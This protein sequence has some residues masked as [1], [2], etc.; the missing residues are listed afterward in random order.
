M[1]YEQESSSLLILRNDGNGNFSEYKNICTTQNVTSLTVGDIN[2]DGIG[3]IAIVHREQNQIEVLISSNK[4]SSYTP[5]QYSVNYYPEKVLIADIDNDNNQDLLCYGKLSSGISVLRGKGDGVF[6]EMKIIF[7]EIPVAEIFIQQFNDDHFADIVLKN[8][9]TNDITFYFGM[10]NLSFSHQ[11]TAGAGSDSVSI[12]FGDFNND[13]ITDFVISS[14]QKKNLQVYEG[15]GIGGF[16]MV[17]TMECSNNNLKLF[18]GAV[19]NSEG[20]DII[21]FNQRSGSFSLFVNRGDGLLY[22]E[23]YFGGTNVATKFLIGD[24]DANTFSDIIAIENNSTHATVYWNGSRAIPFEK[25]NKYKGELVSFCVGSTPSGLTVADFNND[26]IE[27]IAVANSNS[28]TLSMLFGRP[29]STFAGQ[30]SFECIESPVFV[31]FYSKTDSSL[32]FLL[33]HQK[34]PTIS[35]LHLTKQKLDTHQVYTELQTFAVRTAENPQLIIPEAATQNSGI[36]YYV[37]SKALQNSFHYY[38][39]VQSTRFIERSFTP[40]FPSKIFAANIYDFNADGRTDVAYVYYDNSLER[41]Q[42]GITFSDSLDE[43]KN[44]SLSYPLNDSLVQ[45]SYLYFEDF[46]GDGIGDCVLYLF[47]SKTLLIAVGKGNGKFSNFSNVANDIVL[48]LRDHLQILDFD[49]DGI[50]DILI[51]DSSTHELSI[52]R[53][54]GNGKFFTKQFLLDLPNNSVFR[55][56]DFNADGKNDIVFTNPELNSVSV[57]YVGK[58]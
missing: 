38:Q 39:Q 43:Y 12:A 29:L 4:D 1:Y 49:G 9:L 48:S 26:G 20:N 51:E 40:I 54:K 53:G 5:T 35:I 56:G 31:R 13:D 24:I 41:Y 2:N 14:E 10:G 37:Y 15:N 34:K 42:F 19:H 23:T 11:Y 36:E 46:N 52:L 47:P 28:A 6:N 27:D 30:V 57:Y 7:P 58:K 44:N 55:C 25:K 45:Y 21:A 18:V 3:D 22:A 16:H 50:N 32:T 33:T 8:W 17:Q